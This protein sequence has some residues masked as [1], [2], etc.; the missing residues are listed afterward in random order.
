VIKFKNHHPPQSEK[1]RNN[2]EPHMNEVAARGRPF[3]PGVSGNPNGR[4]PGHH[5]R[6]VFSAAFSA[7][8]AETWAQHGKQTMLHTAKHSPE[9]FF[10]TCARLLPKDVELT[11]RQNYSGGL[12]ET[13]LQIL[14]AIRDAIP[15]ANEMQP[16]AV[17]DHVLK[18]VRSYSACPI[19]DAACD[20]EHGITVAKPPINSG[21]IIQA[22]KQSHSGKIPGR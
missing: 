19:I 2:S 3:L 6:H 18:A 22:Q 4:P 7:D 12:D 13:D 10:A 9:A 20:M 21:L 11:I 14:R 1:Q 8:L 16:Q 17:L 5:T 15:N